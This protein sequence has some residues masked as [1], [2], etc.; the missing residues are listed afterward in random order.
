MTNSSS[1]L[2][3]ATRLPGHVLARLAALILVLGIA[4]N[5]ALARESDLLLPI[6]IDADRSEFDERAGLQI[7]E[8]NVRIT[9]GTMLITA[10]RIEVRLK[11]GRLASI[12]GLGSPIQFEQDNELGERMRGSAQSLSYDAVTGSLIL[13][14]NATLQQP[15][16][17]LVSDRIVFDTVSQTV[18]AEGNK[19]D[20][21]SGRV[22]IR[23]EPPER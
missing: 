2:G 12:D 13:Q 20:G 10:E 7:L 6:D 19:S 22:R 3:P 8:G 18:R 4:G 15:R 5:S 14:G 23:I 21:D 9:Q 17:S 16:Q 11:E 1:R